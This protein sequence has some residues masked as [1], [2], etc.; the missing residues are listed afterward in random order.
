MSADLL[1]PFTKFWGSKIN[2]NPTDFTLLPLLCSFH[3]MSSCCRVFIKLWRWLTWFQWRWI[4]VQGLSAAGRGRYSLGLLK[5]SDLPVSLTGNQ[6]VPL[7]DDHKTSSCGAKYDLEK[8][9]DKTKKVRVST[10]DLV[11]PSQDWT[12]AQGTL[13]RNNLFYVQFDWMNRRC[14]VKQDWSVAEEK[15]ERRKGREVETLKNGAMR[16]SEESWLFVKE[17]GR[18]G[19]D[20]PNQ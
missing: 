7:P 19:L 4:H 16:R 8:K 2:S 1:T 14:L 10:L 17:S 15:G 3:K 20:G 5:L 12:V 18:R 13:M 11:Q 6:S 9:K